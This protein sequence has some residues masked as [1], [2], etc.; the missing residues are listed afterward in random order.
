MNIKMLK[1]MQKV[2]FQISCRTNFTQ[3]ENIDPIFAPERW[4]NKM[5]VLTFKNKKQTYIVS[6]I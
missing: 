6:E 1:R 5:S 3:P 4:Q 2:H